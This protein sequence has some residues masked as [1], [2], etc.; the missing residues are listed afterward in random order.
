MQHYKSYM[1]RFHKEPETDIPLFYTVIHAMKQH[2][3]DDNVARFI[4]KYATMAKKECDAVPDNVTPHMFRH[5][6]ALSLY[7]KGVPLPLISNGL[8]IQTLKQL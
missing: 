5:S 1:N 6:R 2:M 7:R 4:R 3:S 8:V